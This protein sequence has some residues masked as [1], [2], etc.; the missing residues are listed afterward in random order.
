LSDNTTPR[1]YRAIYSIGVGYTPPA[2]GNALTGHYGLAFV[3][4]ATASGYKNITGLN[5]GHAL[6]LVSN[7]SVACLVAEMGFWTTS[8]IYAGGDA[9]IQGK[10]W[11]KGEGTVVRRVASIIISASAPGVGDSAP[12]GT[13]W[14][15]T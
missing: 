7:G 10:I 9:T 11:Q 14:L 5:F 12:D 8:N 13:L 1:K 3:Y 2:G 4:D 6:A 15:K